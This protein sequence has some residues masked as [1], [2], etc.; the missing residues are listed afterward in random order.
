MHELHAKGTLTA[1]GPAWRASALPAPIQEAAPLL[2]EHAR[3][4]CAEWLALPA[5]EIEALLAAGVLEEPA[6]PASALP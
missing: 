1:E 5:A 6:T 3:A 2:G 4:V